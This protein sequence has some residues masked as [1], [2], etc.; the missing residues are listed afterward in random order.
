MWLALPGLLF[1]AAFLV[2]PALQLLHL[3]IVDPD[4]GALTGDAYERAFT[5]GVYSRVMAG[6]FSVAA[7]TAVLS[8]VFGYPLAYWLSQLPPARQRTMVLLVLLPF[9]TSA[10]VKNFAWLMLLGRTGIVANTA[11][12]LGIEH[13]PELLFQHGTVVFAMTHT[14][15]PLAVVT[16]LP[17]MSKINPRLLA[18]AQTLGATRAEALWRIFFHL[19]IPG[20][21]AAGLLVFIAS[22]GFFI[23]PALLGGPRE[24]LMGQV[25][26]TQILQLQNWHF[27]SALAAL[28]IAAAL[29][30]CIVFHRVF[31]LSSIAASG[32]TT[33]AD[34]LG[35]KAGIGLLSFIG[36]L[37]RH[38]GRL[39]GAVG[40]AR[41]F[42]WLLPAYAAVLIAVLLVPVL[43][44]IPA[45]FTS[46]SFISFP[47]P[48]F[49]LRWFATYFESP[50]WMTATARSFA[51]GAATACLTIGIAGLAAFGV[52]TTKRR[53][54]N[55][56]FL[57][58]LL[59]MIMPTI[60]TAVGL[61][62]LCARLSLV[63]TDIGIII[64]HTLTAIPIA[65]VILVTA[66]RT[67]D[68]RLDQA[69]YTLGAN[70]PRAFRRVTLPILAGGF[71][72]AFIFAFVHSFEELTVAIF[73]G[74]GL[75]STLP[76]QMWDD[77]LLQVSPTLAAA[78][79]VII[80]IVTSLFLCA[81]YFRY[82]RTPRS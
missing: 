69:A 78:S 21:A 33:S 60:I 70:R 5:V 9:W 41:M 53:T 76:K 82:A 65:F 49:G 61:F 63:A 7:Q 79:A 11:R 43:A 37:F 55:A 80:L 14:M 8:L 18:A 57:V 23:T 58:F 32:S 26:I 47:P 52:V 44:I 71:A 51:I 42:A 17:V 68:F 22:I 66:F 74:G 40:G 39:A 81:E 4:S 3:S 36:T 35:R 6:T 72:A 75:K 10:L 30:S 29:A 25:I 62:Y 24:T 54:A 73:L 50:V 1:L 12:W 67:Y 2:Y 20:V 34:S 46:S 28:L 77:V 15:L 38:L 64:G 31:G 13:P 59:P 16:M 56:I 48:G 45:G 19:S 27:A